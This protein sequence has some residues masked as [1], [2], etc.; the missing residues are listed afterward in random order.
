MCDASPMRVTQ[1]LC[2]IDEHWQ[3]L[4]VRSADQAAS[5]AT[6]GELHGNQHSADITQW[7]ADSQ[8]IG[9]S[10]TFRQFVS[11]RETAPIVRTS[12]SIGA[13]ELDGDHFVTLFIERTPHFAT[14]RRS[15]PRK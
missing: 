1:R 7:R 5:V 6:G 12:Q 3:D 4:V 15:Q 10:Q 14:V 8:H 2:N 9:M 11:V 13:K